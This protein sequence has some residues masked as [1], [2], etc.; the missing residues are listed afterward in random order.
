MGFLGLGTETELRGQP[1]VSY[2]AEGLRQL[3]SGYL[4]LLLTVGKM[5]GIVKNVRMIRDSK[6]SERAGRAILVLN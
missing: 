6:H 2:K 4:S 3:G 5:I 1:I